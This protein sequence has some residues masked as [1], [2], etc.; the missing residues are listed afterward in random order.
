MSQQMSFDELKTLNRRSTC[1]KTL[2]SLEIDIDRALLMRRSDVAF[3]SAEIFDELRQKKDSNVYVFETA[4]RMLEIVVIEAVIE[5]KISSAYSDFSDVFSKEAAQ[6][7][8]SH[9]SHDHAIDIEDKELTFDSIYNLSTIELKIL[10]EY[11]D[12]H[13]KR[14]FITFSVSS[15]ESSILFVKKK[16]ESLRLCVNYR[17]L[18]EIIIKNRYS[19]SLIDETLDRLIETKIYTKMNIRFVYNLIRIRERDE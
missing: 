10:R 16:N 6:K 2:I 14:E 15:T 4:S 18:N 5:L 17:S 9:D 13:L 1:E 11:I 3:V 12:D 8:S 19:L 7:L